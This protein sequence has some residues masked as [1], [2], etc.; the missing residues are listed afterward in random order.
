MY[1]CMVAPKGQNTTTYNNT[2]HFGECKDTEMRNVAFSEMLI[3]VI[4]MY[5]CMVAPR[6]KTQQTLTH[7]IS[8]NTIFSENVKTI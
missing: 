7:N 3:T 2:Q 1:I 5:V 6:V 8:Q 4:C